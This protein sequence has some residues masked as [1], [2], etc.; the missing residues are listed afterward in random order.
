[1]Q[2]MDWPLATD[3]WRLQIHRNAA[4][5]DTK[6][7][8]L[9]CKYDAFRSNTVQR[10]LLRLLLSFFCVLFSPLVL[11]FSFLIYEIYENMLDLCQTPFNQ[12]QISTAGAWI[13][14]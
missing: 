12:R 14:E 7:Q 3:A 11:F 5:T 1:M 2:R 13:K 9:R 10:T 8:P 4:G 6:L